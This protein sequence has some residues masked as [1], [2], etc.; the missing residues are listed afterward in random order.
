MAGRGAKASEASEV[1]SGAFGGPP[2]ALH[3]RLT[4]R[5]RATRQQIVDAAVDI[6]TTE[7]YDALT[8]RAAGARA[9]VA[10]GTVYRY[11]TSKDH[12]LVTA[13]LDW[14]ERFIAAV[15]ADPPTGATAAERVVEVFTRFAEQGGR[16]PR[17]LDA[18]FRA[19]MSTDP[20]V[21][22]LRVD[23]RSVTSRLVELAIGDVAIADRDDVLHVFED[24]VSAALASPDVEGRRAGL[25]EHV[26]RAARLLLREPR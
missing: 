2:V 9:G 26:E 4:A 22:A 24:V 14:S 7:G 12:M 5:Q 6:A 11:F 13:M 8:T 1:L 15:A 17:L 16:R 21:V 10:I 25:V 19:G 3:R 18:L 20:T 23:Q